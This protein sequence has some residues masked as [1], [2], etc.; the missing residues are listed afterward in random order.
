M[1]GKVKIELKDL[2][3]MRNELQELK[4]KYE[5]IDPEKYRYLE[6]EL[7]RYKKNNITESDMGQVLTVMAQALK[8]KVPFNSPA[9]QGELER[10]GICVAL[11]EGKFSNFD[12]D[13][14]K[15]TKLKKT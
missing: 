2:D 8:R 5:G 10:I 11:S 1:K 4:T 3:A 6:E 9:V 14:F 7:K 15:I 13:K 12:Q